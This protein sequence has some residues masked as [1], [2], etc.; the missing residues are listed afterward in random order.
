MVQVFVCFLPKIT[1]ELLLMYH[2]TFQTYTLQVLVCHIHVTELNTSN[3][4][5]YI[6]IIRDKFTAF[7]ISLCQKYHFSCTRGEFSS[8]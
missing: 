4:D 1:K 7:E 2:N 8:L 6:H 5:I 3:L